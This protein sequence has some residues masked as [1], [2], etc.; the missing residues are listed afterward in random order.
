LA[1]RRQSDPLLLLL[2]LLLLQAWVGPRRGRAS[3]ET[4]TCC[5]WTRP[6]RG[7]LLC[8]AAPCLLLLEAGGAAKGRAEDSESAAVH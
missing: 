5:W 2:L 4:P 7:S 6:L 8:S 3:L 1:L